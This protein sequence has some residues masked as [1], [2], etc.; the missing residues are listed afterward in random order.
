MGLRLLTNYPELNDVTRS[1]STNV[2]LFGRYFHSTARADETRNSTPH[3]IYPTD[4]RMFMKDYPISPYPK[5]NT[6]MIEQCSNT[7]KRQTRCKKGTFNA[8][9]D[10]P[11]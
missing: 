9:R 3:S 11:W 7:V 5:F 8:G 6:G 2:Q 4:T 10:L 1:R